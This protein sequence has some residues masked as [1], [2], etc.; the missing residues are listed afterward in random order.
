[1]VPLAENIV[2]VAM[3]FESVVSVSVGVPLINVPLAPV[4]GAVN[5]T[6]TPLA[7]FAPP[8]NTVAVMGAAKDVL[9]AALCGVPL[10]AAIVAGGPAMFISAKVAG[11]VTPATEAV[12][13]S[14]PDVPFAVNIAEVATPFASVVALVIVEAVSANMPLAPVEGAANV[15]TASLTGFWPP[16]L[17]VTTSGTPKV[18]L[19]TTLC[20]FPLIEVI[21]AGAPVVFVRLKLAGAVI[22]ELDAVTV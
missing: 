20:E 9:I 8:S 4:A 5:V 3:P 16:S 22:P 14:G 18:V 1:M 6:R 15:T 19:T 7:G 2:D 10:L 11:V 12:T 13:V 17:T 21:A